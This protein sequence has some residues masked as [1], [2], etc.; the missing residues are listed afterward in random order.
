M[1]GQRIVRNLL[2]LVFFSSGATVL[3]T[4]ILCNDLLDHYQNKALLAEMEQS[5]DKLE[6]LD[7]DYDILLEQ[8]EQDPNTLRRLAPAA[9]GIEPNEPNTV[10]PKATAEE[11]D[12][13]RMVLMEPTSQETLDAA[14]PELLMRCCRPRRRAALIASGAFLVIIAFMFFGPASP[15]KPSYRDPVKESRDEKY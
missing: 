2:F 15:P 12:A 7:E 14:T 5:I 1:A 4:M 6:S 11:L 3:A 9:L 13:A 8:V 10:F